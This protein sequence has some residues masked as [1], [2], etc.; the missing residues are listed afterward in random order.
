MLLKR[1]KKPLK[2]NKVEKTAEEKAEEA[3]KTKINNFINSKNIDLK[4]NDSVLENLKNKH[5][6]KDDFIIC[7]KGM[8]TEDNYPL[9][10]ISSIEKLRKENNKIKL[11]IIN[12]KEFK[13]NEIINYDWIKLIFVEEQ[14]YYKYLK[15]SDILYLQGCSDEDIIYYYL[16]KKPILSKK[17]DNNVKYLGRNYPGFYKDQEEII[18][19]LYYLIN[20][21]NNFYFNFIEKKKVLFLSP[22]IVWNK[23]MGNS[24]WASNFLKIIKKYNNIDIDILYCRK[25]TNNIDFAFPEILSFC[26]VINLFNNNNYSIWNGYKTI[27][28]NKLINYIKKTYKYYDFII[29]RGPKL[30]QNICNLNPNPNKIIYVQQNKSIE[31][32]F[33]NNKMKIIHMTFLEFFE[34]KNKNKY[35]IPPLLYKNIIINNMN[36]KYDYCFVGTLHNLSQINVVLDVFSKQSK[37]IIIAGLCLNDYKSSLDV[38]ISKYD[39]NKNIIFNVPKE[40]LSD[41]ECNNIISESRVGIRIDQISECLSSKLLTYINYEKI[42]LIQRTK[43]HEIIFGEN[44]PFFLEQKEKVSKSDFSNIVDKINNY[45]KLDDITKVIKNVKN[46][47]NPEKLILNNYNI[48]F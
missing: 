12:E 11:L 14:D 28:F 6:K 20:S 13:I 44:Y 16:A 21:K 38:L 2:T 40:G 27:Y 8:I 43:T 1:K 9:H 7:L 25:T 45:Y 37:R 48:K 36:L 3:I 42:C 17:N 41:D 10:L 34:N 18:K 35:I 24:I 31:K 4:I 33:L 23:S 29:I 22:E 46:K 19:I 47:I 39:K 15:M 26:N 32:N 30:M 5:F